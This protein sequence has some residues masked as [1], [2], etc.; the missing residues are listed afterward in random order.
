MNKIIIRDGAIIYSSYHYLKSFI[1]N[2]RKT[3]PYYM[4]YF[5]HLSG[6]VSDG[7]N[8]R[9]Q[10]KSSNPNI[11]Y[12]EIYQF[13]LVDENVLFAHDEKLKSKIQYYFD[14]IELTDISLGHLGII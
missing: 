9:V 11:S 1:E 12:D 2:R 10:P 5:E 13:Q 6:L 7:S 4:S 8:K 3:D 14:M